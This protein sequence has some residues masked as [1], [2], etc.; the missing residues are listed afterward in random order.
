MGFERL[1]RFVSSMGET[2]Y[3]NLTKETPTKEIQ[4]SE[5]EILKGD[6]ESGFEKA[7]KK[8]T[9]K[10]VSHTA[11]RWGVLRMAGY[12]IDMSINVWK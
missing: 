7:G 5:V 6:I 2:Q 11:F 3:G 1:I 8:A 4:G 9:V 10:Q 12:V